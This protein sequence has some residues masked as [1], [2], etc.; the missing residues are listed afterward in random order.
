MP[1]GKNTGNVRRRDYDGIGRLFFVFFA[2]KA[3]GFHP[4]F[5][6]AVFDFGWLV[7]FI[8]E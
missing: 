6:E 1:H 7:G 2:G 3:A 4:L 8:H 5:V